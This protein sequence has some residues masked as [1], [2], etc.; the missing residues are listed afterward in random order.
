FF[1]IFLDLFHPIF[2]GGLWK[3]SCVDILSVHMNIPACDR[4]KDKILQRWSNMYWQESIE[5]THILNLPDHIMLYFIK[6]FFK[7]HL[8]ARILSNIKTHHMLPILGFHYIFHPALYSHNKI[9][10]RSI[11]GK[12][13]AAGRAQA[14][15]TLA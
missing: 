2:R 7:I 4:N 15:T 8:F 10:L 11:R 13:V 6:S 12:E 9:I 5:Y 14:H 3:L 1:M